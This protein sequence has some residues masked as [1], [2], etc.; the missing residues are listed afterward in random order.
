MGVKCVKIRPEQQRLKTLPICYWRLQESSAIAMHLL[1]ILLQ[2]LSNKSWAY[3]VQTF[4][5]SIFLSHLLDD[6]ILET[7][8]IAY[9]FEFGSEQV[10]RKAYCLGNQGHFRSAKNPSHASFCRTVNYDPFDHSTTLI[11]YFSEKKWSYSAIPYQLCNMKNL[12]CQR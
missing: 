12:E 9:I 1:S 2:K 5:K 4:W 7:Y 11:P 8:S 3:E 10:L 6:K